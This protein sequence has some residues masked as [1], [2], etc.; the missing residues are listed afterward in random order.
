M[1]QFLKYSSGII[2][3]ITFLICLGTSCSML[4]YVKPEGQS[5]GSCRGTMKHTTG[6]ITPFAFDIFKEQ[7]GTLKFFFRTGRFGRYMPVGDVSFE[8]GIIR[9]E[10]D[11]P[12]RV[13]KGTIS[14]NDLSFKG[15]WGEYSGSFAI[16]LKK[17][18]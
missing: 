4:P 2:L 6:K 11:S 8:D 16:D 12:H 17:K 18:E 1:K 14:G 15:Q 10:V 9:V 13:Y 5:V 3:L 7:D